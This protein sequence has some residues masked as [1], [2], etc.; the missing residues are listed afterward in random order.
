MCWTALPIRKHVQ[1]KYRL[2][3]LNWVAMKP[4]QVKGTLFSELDDEKLYNVSCH[5]LFCSAVDF[6]EHSRW[7]MKH[8]FDDI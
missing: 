4:N 1:P 3:V 2:P 6:V 8:I 5:I 7:L